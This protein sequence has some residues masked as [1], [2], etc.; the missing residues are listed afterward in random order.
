MKLADYG[1]DP[2]VV[3]ELPVAEEFQP[4]PEGT[5]TVRIVGFDLNRTKDG[6]GVYFKTTFTIT[7]GPYANRQV[8]K[9]INYINK[10]EQA[11]IIGRQELHTVFDAAGITGALHD[12]N[13]AIN[14]ILKAK[15][16]IKEQEGFRPTNEVKSIMLAN[17]TTPSQTSSAPKVARPWG[18]R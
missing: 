5:Y 16:V 10:S 14:A 11:Q 4:V 7:E 15:V 9:N 17:N 18:Q 13:E 1:L 8:F 3:N 12:T 2:I 6:T